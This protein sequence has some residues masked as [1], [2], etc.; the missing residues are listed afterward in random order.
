VAVPVPLLNGKLGVIAGSNYG[1]ATLQLTL[2]Q[3]VR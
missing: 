2:H 1:P 3:T